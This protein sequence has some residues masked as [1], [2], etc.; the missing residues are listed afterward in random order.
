MST[1]DYSEQLFIKDRIQ[2]TYD[3]N[4]RIEFGRAGMALNGNL[5]PTGIATDGQALVCSAVTGVL[6]WGEGGG[7]GVDIIDSDTY[8]D[9]VPAQLLWNRTDENL[10]AGLTGYGGHWIQINSVAQR[11]ATG[12]GTYG[13]T[14]APGLQGVTGA[15]G[16]PQGPQGDTGPQGY[17]GVTG[18]QGIQGSTGVQ[19]LG[20]TGLQGS[21][22]VQGI[23]G[24]TGVQ[25][26]GL[27]GLQGVTGSTMPAVPM[28]VAS[29]HN[30][31][32]YFRLAAGTPRMLMA[33]PI[34]LTSSSKVSI[35][36][37]AEVYRQGELGE[38]ETTVTIA[39]YTGTQS[40]IEA[41]NTVD[42]NVP[43]NTPQSSWVT[44]TLSPG[45][46]TGAVFIR[47]I[48]GAGWTG[49]LKNGN[50]AI[51]VLEG[52][53]GVT[54]YQGVTGFRGLTGAQGIT[55]IRGTTGIQGLVGVT[56]AYGGPQGVTGAQGLIGV[57]GAYGGPAGVTGVQGVTG[58]KNN[59]WAYTGLQ[60]DTLAIDFSSSEVVKVPVT[61]SRTL[62]TTVPA[63]GSTRV[64]M[65]LK[66]GTTA[67]T[68]TFGTGFK[69]TATLN[70]GTTNA[71]QFTVSWVSDG[72]NLYE[73]AR[74]A[75]M[76]A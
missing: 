64:L 32:E 59:S 27:T 49:Q 39:G 46:Y 24:S 75:A 58:V 9:V 54:G 63:A 8:P 43:Y 70:A 73:Q 14:G 61:A 66:S 50:M 4:A 10:Y 22:G 30:Q 47:D 41:Q 72:T 74:T 19:G 29:I 25:G 53:T 40:L 13:T 17:N 69:P 11:G 5:F 71:R 56:G 12:L 51:T 34:L 42:G 26:L 65:V 35:D 3:P 20:L 16:G 52:G 23:A 28:N 2:Y 76:V 48:T 6:E 1:K 36:Y 60:A 67:A 68:I 31:T 44:P 37:S 7:G 45:T 57:T 15:Y 18:I 62:T 38:A 55:G 21:T 33:V